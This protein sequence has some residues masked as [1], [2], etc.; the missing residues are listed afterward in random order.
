MVVY[1]VVQVVGYFNNCPVLKKYR[2][3]DHTSQV[4]SKSATQQRCISF[5]AESFVAILNRTR[6]HS[7]FLTVD[8]YIGTVFLESLEQRPDI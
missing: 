2:K 6:I 4:A 1:G 3:F 8:V 5:I 7:L